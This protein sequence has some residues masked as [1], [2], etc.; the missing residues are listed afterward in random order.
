MSNE[1]EN[2]DDSLQK[3]VNEQLSVDEE[4]A[5][6]GTTGNVGKESP[7]LRQIINEQVIEGEA[8]GSR[9][10]TLRKILGGDI[11]TTSAVRRQIWVL[12]LITGFIFFY[13]SNR[14]S[15]QKNM[16][17][18]DQLENELTDAKYKAL[19]SSSKLTELSRESN[20]LQVLQNNKDSALK[21]PT[22]P[23]YIIEIPNK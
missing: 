14:Y 3:D 5:D 6:N 11:L 15:C 7:S 4:T 18:I 2:I 8:H 12:L 1:N 21:A 19:S 9:N 20:V 13:I 17:E 22:Q 23:P 16:I 10:F